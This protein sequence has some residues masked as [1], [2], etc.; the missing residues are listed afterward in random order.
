MAFILYFNNYLFLL[1]V[2]DFSEAVSPHCDV[3]QF[4]NDTAILRHAKNEANLQLIA[5][6]T[7]NRTDQY[8]KQNCLTLNEEKR[9]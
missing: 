3:L 6:D 8:M 2:N 9:S 4:A 1:Y 7:L 5:E